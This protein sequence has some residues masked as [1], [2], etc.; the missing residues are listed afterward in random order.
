ME[1]HPHEEPPDRHPWRTLA[2][3]EAG[4]ILLF[5]GLLFAILTLT[6]NAGVKYEGPSVL[7]FYLFIAGVGALYG[8][9]RWWTH[10]YGPSNPFHDRP[11]GGQ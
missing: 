9:E 8:F 3:C 6:A 1:Y 5:V 7:N 10:E 4:G 2:V 11:S